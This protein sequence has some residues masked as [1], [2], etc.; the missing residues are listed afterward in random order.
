MEKIEKRLFL[1]ELDTFDLQRIVSEVNN[2]SK[3]VKELKLQ[4]QFG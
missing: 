1:V 3:R 2:L 4:C